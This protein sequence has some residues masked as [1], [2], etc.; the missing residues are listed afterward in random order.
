MKQHWPKL[1]L[2]GAVVVV[3]L[4]LLFSSEA[5]TAAAELLVQPI[6]G[7]FQVAV[8]V[9]GELRAKNDVKIYGPTQARQ[10]RIYEMKIQRL[11]P[12]GTVVAPGDF[13][14]QL[15]QSELNSR[16][17]DAQIEL[18]KAASQYTQTRLDTSLTLSKARDELV[19]LRYA[20]EEARLRK[21]QAVYEPP[22][23]Q[24][25][26]EIDYEKAQRSLNQS[27][28]NYSVQVDQAI[29]KMSEVGAELSKAQKQVDE[30]QQLASTFTILA[31]QDGMLIY[32]RDWRGNKTAQGGTV[33]AWD[34]VVATL[35]D[36]SVME[37]VVYV[38]EVDIQKIDVGQPVT[39]SLDADPD[40]RL[41]G[42]VTEVANIGEQRPNSDAKVFE[43]VIEINEEDSDL[44]P[45]MTTANTIIVA[46]V[47]QALAIP[48]ECIH[49]ADSVQFVYKKQGGSTVRQEV[50]LGLF[51][52]NE[53][54]VEA[55]LDQDDEVFMSLP[56]DPSNVPL[57]RLEPGLAGR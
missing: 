42:V 37:S 17:Q 46:D 14:A 28:K 31:P 33:N 49:T 13:V 38:N 24:R 9:T 6:E 48:L 19:N 25:Q 23:V 10:F 27:T 39:I 36:L 56:P 22:S 1:A 7:P 26:A 51:N 18:Q 53:A 44:R 40:K 8:T 12:E 29:A 30:L 3:L 50:R 5:E 4:V 35:P 32:K 43:V 57:R 34:P 45:A 54:I 20:M 2:G 47:P 21:D 52:E 15:D 11:I 16:I 55:G 41:T